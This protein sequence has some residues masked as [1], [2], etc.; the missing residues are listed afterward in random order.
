[1]LDQPQG[2]GTVVTIERALV[3]LLLALLLLGVFEVLR[4]FIT[5]ILFGAI[6]AVAAWPARQ[7]L[8][9]RGLP[10]GAAATV[11]LLLAICLLALPALTVAPRLVR[12]IAHGG[13]HLSEL[14]ATVPPH[15]PGW[16]ASLPLI[17]N[18]IAG[19]WATTA[20]GE[21]NA[22]GSVLAPYSESLRHALIAVAGGLADSLLQIVLALGIAT[23]FW[24][25]GREM[26]RHVQEVL[27]LLAGE[28]GTQALDA[29]AASVRGVTYGVI[30][31]AVLQ[32]VLM[33]GALSA[34]GIR[35][36]AALGLLTLVLSLSQIGLPLVYGIVLGS[37]WWSFHIGSVGWAIFLLAF[38]APLSLCDNVIRP[39]LIGFGVPMPLLLVFLGVFGGFVSFGF[40]GLFIGPSVLAVAFTL[41]AAWRSRATQLPPLDPPE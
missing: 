1:M 9:R 39:W 7:A 28:A 6:V 40:L 24:I 41:L 36:A 21:L 18:E 23:V 25:H 38:C 29:A 30:G 19:T 2:S 26:A 8:V 34:A 32:A 11:L 20:S 22:L 5:A 3:L 37:A 13:E 31:T 16:L 12:Q 35:G 10:A 4:P 15:A 33:T 27:F 17:G 14:L